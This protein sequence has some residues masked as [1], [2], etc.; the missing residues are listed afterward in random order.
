MSGCARYGTVATVMILQ[1]D[2]I[3]GPQYLSQR[4]FTCKIHLFYLRFVGLR[5]K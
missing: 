4:R 1:E 5:L 2:T 3:H